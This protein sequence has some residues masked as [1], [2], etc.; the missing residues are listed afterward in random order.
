[1]N[2][3]EMTA[4]LVAADKG[5]N[6]QSKMKGDGYRWERINVSHEQ[7]NFYLY[8]YR[9]KPV[10]KYRTCGDPVNL[11]GPKFVEIKALEDA[12]QIVNILSVRTGDDVCTNPC[13]DELM[14]LIK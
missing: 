13:Y 9:I 4:V 2:Y 1:M 3:A 6:V 7:F 8:D 12:M 5:E 10:P 11:A 14:E